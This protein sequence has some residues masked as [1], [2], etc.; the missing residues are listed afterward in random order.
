MLHTHPGN[1]LQL[2]PAVNHA[3]GVAGVVEDQGLGFGSNGGGKLLRSH[4]K[5]GPLPRRNHHWLAAHHLDHLQVAHPIGSGQYDLVTRVY[6]SPQ[7]Q[8]DAVLRPGG[9]HYLGGLVIQPAVLPHPL[10]DRFLQFRGAGGR[11]IPGQVGGNGPVRRRLDVSRSIEIRLAGTEADHINAFCLHLL[12]QR[13]NCHGAGDL[14]RGR[15][16]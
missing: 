16:P 3:G 7:S 5:P 12:G 1:G 8:I 14:Y 4:F 2:L 10:A 6:H 11:G 15:N 13:V 9:H